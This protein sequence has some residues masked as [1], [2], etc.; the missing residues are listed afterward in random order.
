M[1]IDGAKRKKISVSSEK[2]ANAR[3]LWERLAK[4]RPGPNNKDLLY[5]ARFVPLL[6]ASAVKTLMTRSLSFED[7]KELIQ[8]VPKARDAAVQLALKDPASLSEGDLRFLVTQTQSVEAAR[9]LIRRNPGNAVLGFVERNIE[10][11]RD[12]V[13]EVRQKEQTT[14]VLREIDRVL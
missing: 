13:E 2:K 11:L 5:L 12:V 14:D 9:L 4:S 7:L 10:Q 1:A 8:H 6:S 3:E